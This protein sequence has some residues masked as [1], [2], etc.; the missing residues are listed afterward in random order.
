MD[1]QTAVQNSIE[2]PVIMTA[3]VIMQWNL[4]QL[5]N[6]SYSLH[7]DDLSWCGLEFYTVTSP[8]F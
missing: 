5:G 2:N 4:P 1:Q 8:I 6:L 7:V 3:L